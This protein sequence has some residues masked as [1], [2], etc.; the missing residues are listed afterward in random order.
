MHSVEPDQRGIMQLHDTSELQP[1]NFY[2]TS[3]SAAVH[4]AP[5]AV[6][7]CGI[8]CN[9][10]AYE[11]E[12]VAARRRLQYG[13]ECSV[14]DACLV[15]AITILHLNPTCLWEQQQRLAEHGGGSSQDQQGYAPCVCGLQM[16]PPHC[17]P[18]GE[19]P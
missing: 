12:A 19:C 10:L 7:Q 16:L 14:V 3:I 9:M 4:S 18:A 17:P 13:A 5:Y 1:P 2:S 11:S 15:P 6:R 8:T